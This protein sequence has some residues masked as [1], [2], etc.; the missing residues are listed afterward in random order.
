MSQLF[1]FLRSYIFRSYDLRS[2]NIVLFSFLPFSLLFSRTVSEI[3]ISLICLSFLYVVVRQGQ[4]RDCITGSVGVLLIIW[5]VLNLVVSPQAINPE[6]SFTRSLLWIRFVLLFAAVSLWLIRSVDDL[7]IVGTLWALTLGWV[8]L[9]GFV[10]LATNVSLSGQERPGTRLTG[11]LDRPNIGT[12]V[13]KLSFPAVV[14]AVLIGRDAAWPLRRWAA[15][16][17]WVAVAYVFVILSGERSITMLTCVAVFCILGFLVLFVPAWRL[18]ALGMAIYAILSF[19]GLSWFSPTVSQRAELFITHTRDF[20]SSIY[21][22]LFEAGLRIWMDNPITGV[23]LKGF[24]EFK[25]AAESD[26]LYGHLHP[27]NIYIEWLCET[28]LT[29]FIGFVTFVMVVTLPV[30][31]LITAGVHD[32]LVGLL[33][34]GGLIV[35]LFPV[36]VTQ[37]FFSNWSA[38]LF[39]IA[40]SSI[41][42]MTRIVLTDSRSHPVKVGNT[43][44]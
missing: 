17:L 37:S 40:L 34:A 10:Q 29:G 44:S 22:Q 18:R 36:A 5:I 32:R 19:V 43:T 2:L 27:H 13:A 14:M 38:M 31:R 30:M 3:L 7:R 33:L 11:P 15:L 35:L 6:S 16:G 20:W 39:W 28:G 25:P 23:G 9:D 12:F 42:A 21:G 1:N 4:W 8:M 41:V 26:D 24:R